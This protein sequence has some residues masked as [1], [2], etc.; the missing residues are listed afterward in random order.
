MESLLKDVV[1]NVFLDTSGIFDCTTTVDGRASVDSVHITDMSHRI[2][3]AM[4]SYSVDESGT[5]FR[6]TEVGN[7]VYNACPRDVSALFKYCPQA[8]VFGA[9]NSFG[10][11]KKRTAKFPRALSA[12]II[13]YKPMALED[14][15]LKVD[16][17]NITTKAMPDV[18]KASAVGLGSVPWDR[19]N[20]V[21]LGGGM[22]RTFVL[23]D[24][25]IRSLRFGTDDADRNAAGQQAIR[26]L[27]IHANNIFLH[28]MIEG[29]SLRS[30]CEVYLEN[31]TLPSLENTLSSLNQ[32][33]DAASSHGLEW[34][35]DTY[36][37][38]PT[39]A[40]AKAI[41]TSE[42]NADKADKDSK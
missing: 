9:W 31:A 30:G 27:A 2:Y 24:A 14:H 15:G 16:V 40:L 4:L 18:K 19:S 34:A 25:T 7:S 13:G 6:E 21:T 1:P 33:R 37:F 20:R 5:P 38:L 8:L 28:Q 3:D 23:S 26:A 42:E 17:L 35:T 11:K 41:K 29:M 12:E 10:S 36:R 39:P 32:A 22:F